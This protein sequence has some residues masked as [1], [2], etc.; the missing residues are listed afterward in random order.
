VFFVGTFFFL[1]HFFFFSGKSFNNS[2]PKNKNP[3]A[4]A[5]GLWLRGRRRKP[6]P[7]LLQLTGLAEDTHQLKDFVNRPAEL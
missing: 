6:P 5:W 4:T 3:Q 7:P 2:V 1:F